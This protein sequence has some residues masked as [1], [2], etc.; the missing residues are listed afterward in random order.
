MPAVIDA[1][2]Y[3][4]DVRG[5]VDGVDAPAGVEVDDAVAAD[6]AVEELDVVAVR[7]VAEDAGLEESGVAGSDAL[8][9]VAAAAGGAAAAVGDGIA[10][11][12]YAHGGDGGV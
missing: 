12:E 1:D 8:G 5:E 4:Q 7:V 6:G 3:G 9:L 2:E 11:E 10:L